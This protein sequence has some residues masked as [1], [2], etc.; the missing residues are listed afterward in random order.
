MPGWRAFVGKREVSVR[1][2][3]DIFQ[4]I[5]LPEGVSTVHFVY[6]PTGVRPAVWI[7]TGTLVAIFAGLLWFSFLHERSASLQ[8]KPCNH[9]SR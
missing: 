9:R 1:K 2:V 4:E 3:G 7:S 5:D 8:G 6:A